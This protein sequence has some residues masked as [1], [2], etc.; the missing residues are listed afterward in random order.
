MCGGCP[1]FFP[2]LLLDVMRWVSYFTFVGCDAVGVLFYLF[3][4][5]Y[6]TSIQW[7]SYFT[8]IYGA[9]CRCPKL[10]GVQSYLSYCS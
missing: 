4:F 9:N 1:R 8:L 7:V 5:H 3:Y 6:F 2:R 10:V